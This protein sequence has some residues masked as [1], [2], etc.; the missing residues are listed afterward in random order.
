[1][2]LLPDDAEI[3]QFKQLQ[4]KPVNGILLNVQ[5]YGVN[6]EKQW[7]DCWSNDEPKKSGYVWQC[8]GVQ[9]V[10]KKYKQTKFYQVSWQR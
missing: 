10:F 3:T 1:M 6:A 2:C 7:A 4:D 9:F 8:N 5:F